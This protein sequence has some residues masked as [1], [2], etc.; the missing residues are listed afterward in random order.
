LSFVLRFFRLVLAPTFEALRGV[1]PSFKEIILLESG[2]KLER[3][4]H[5]GNIYNCQIDST[6]PV[7]SYVILCYDI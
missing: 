6:I 1:P 5:T 4:F 7:W 3:Y 2:S